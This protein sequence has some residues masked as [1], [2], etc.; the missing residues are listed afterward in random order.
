M[1]LIDQKVD[2]IKKTGN[3]CWLVKSEPLSYGIQDLQKEKK[4]IWDGVRNYQARNFMQHSMKPGDR[5]L[6]YHSNAHPPGVAGLARVAEGGAIPDP[7]QFDPE[8][9]YYAPKASPE[10]PIWYC[11]EVLYEKTFE[12]MVT[13]AEIKSHPGL[14][15]MLLAQKGVRLSVQPVTEK[16]YL[17]VCSLARV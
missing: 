12:R 10:K 16:E 4:C 11:V 8:S 14:R 6:F 2:E 3:G 1:G 15:N 13:L 17:T 7:T 5:V 9:D